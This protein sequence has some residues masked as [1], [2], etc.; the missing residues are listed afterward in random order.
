RLLLAEF[1]E[2]GLI[3][4]ARRAEEDGGV[5]GLA[6]GRKKWHP[7][8]IPLLAGLVD[9]WLAE[10]EIGQLQVGLCPRSLAYERRDF[11]LFRARLH[12]SGKG[13]H[14]KGEVCRD[15]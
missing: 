3:L 7:D 11:R 6:R 2:L 12:L 15:A 8:V 13:H 14:L 1:V 4:D 9:E 5:S 10:L